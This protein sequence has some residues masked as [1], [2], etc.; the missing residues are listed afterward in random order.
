MAIN[1]VYNE[2]ADAL[3]PH[4]YDATPKAVFAAVAV[5]A[6]TRADGLALDQCTHT[7]LRA[8]VLREWVVLHQNGIIPQKPPGRPREGKSGRIGDAP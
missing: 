3:G 2:Y 1:K 5:S 7:E 6:L 8:A 4:F